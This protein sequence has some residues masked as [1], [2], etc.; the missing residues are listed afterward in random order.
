MIIEIVN[1]K[2][3]VKKTTHSVLT[4]VVFRSEKELYTMSHVNTCVQY[5]SHTLIPNFL[6]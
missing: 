3:K 1:H 5:I 4:V 6:Q 2:Q